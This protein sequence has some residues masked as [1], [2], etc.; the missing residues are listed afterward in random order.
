ME[1]LI[2]IIPAVTHP[3]TLIAFGIAALL[4]AYGLYKRYRYKALEGV[5]DPETRLKMLS[6]LLGQ[7]TPDMGNLKREQKAEIINTQIQNGLTR[8]KWMAIIFGGLSTLVILAAIII[9]LST[10]NVVDPRKQ[11]DQNTDPKPTA[12]PSLPLARLDNFGGNGL[13][14]KGGDTYMNGN[15]YRV[16]N[17]NQNEPDMAY[18]LISF[19]LAKSAPGGAIKLNEV[20]VN[21]EPIERK[22]AVITSTVVA[23]FSPPLTFAAKLLRQ[24]SAISATMKLGGETID[25]LISFTDDLPVR[26]FRL[27]FEGEPGLYVVSSVE[28]DVQDVR[29]GQKLTVKSDKSVFIVL[30]DPVDRGP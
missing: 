7:Y 13:I 19:D 30:Q 10:K 22:L 1:E 17:P 16:L 4:S 23:N 11:A 20:R 29:T 5:S 26:K 14:H 9:A 8:F 2:R 18:P 24:K 6:E 25:G 28:L 15:V 12:V 3:V 21:F 27:E